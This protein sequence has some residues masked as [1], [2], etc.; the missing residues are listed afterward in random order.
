MKVSDIDESEIVDRKYDWEEYEVWKEKEYVIECE[1]TEDEYK[2]L[3][4][5][6][7]VVKKCQ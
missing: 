2:K 1:L 5:S 3:L 4:E 6:R 7:F